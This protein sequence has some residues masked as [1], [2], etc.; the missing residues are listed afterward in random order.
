MA[1]FV[2][3][4]VSDAARARAQLARLYPNNHLDLDDAWLISATGTAKDVSDRLGLSTEN[5]WSGIIFKMDN[6]YGRAPSD[7]WDWIKDK[8]EKTSG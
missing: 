6:Y 3:F 7:L 8:A 2:L 1:I 5:T 4:R